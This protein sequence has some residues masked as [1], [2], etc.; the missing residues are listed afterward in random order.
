MIGGSSVGNPINFITGNKL[1]DE[2][3][4]PAIGDSPLH[5]SRHYNSLK[6]YQYQSG[7]GSIGRSRDPMGLHWWHNYHKGLT[8]KSSTV[9]YTREN[10][11]TFTY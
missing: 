3:D 1:L 2:T 9:Q 4:I 6:N 11:Q 8:V 7:F 5:F 10:G